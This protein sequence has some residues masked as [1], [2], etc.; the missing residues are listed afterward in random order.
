MKLKK[1]IDKEAIEI[2]QS[3]K[4]EDINKSRERKIKYLKV[5]EKNYGED[6]WR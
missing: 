4:E 3:M 5:L 6:I 2:Y 1:E